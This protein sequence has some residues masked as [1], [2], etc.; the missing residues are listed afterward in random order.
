MNGVYTRDY[1]HFQTHSHTYANFCSYTGTHT[2]MRTLK[3]WPD[4][5]TRWHRWRFTTHTY[6]YQHWTHEL[7]RTAQNPCEHTHTRT[8]TLNMISDEL[9]ELRTISVDANGPARTWRR[10]ERWKTYV[11]SARLDSVQVAKD[12]ND[13][14]SVCPHLCAEESATDDVKAQWW[15]WWFCCYSEKKM[16]KKLKAFAWVCAEYAKKFDA[17]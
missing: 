7:S 17:I 1:S 6:L 4:H 10:C 15:W 12:H 16:G 11:V 14:H 2:H 5:R 3:L 13:D 9:A 8:H